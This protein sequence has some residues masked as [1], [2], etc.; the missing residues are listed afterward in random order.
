VHSRILCPVVAPVTTRKEKQKEAGERKHTY[1]PLEFMLE[2]K[3][4]ATCLLTI[5]PV[6]STPVLYE[7]E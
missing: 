7:Q 6:S 4:V 5:Y 3:R 1:T 2:M